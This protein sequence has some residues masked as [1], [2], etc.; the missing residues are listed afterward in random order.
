M[1]N[2]EIG[3]YLITVLNTVPRTLN[4]TPKVY[5]ICLFIHGQSNFRTNSYE[6]IKFRQKYVLF[7]VD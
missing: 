7:S 5:K 1:E 4:F 6:G 2:V 3:N